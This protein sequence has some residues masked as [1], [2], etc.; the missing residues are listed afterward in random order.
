M[1]P[2]ACCRHPGVALL[3]ESPRALHHAARVCHNLHGTKRTCGLHA[4]DDHVSDR[5][6]V[7]VIAAL[8]LFRAHEE[9]TL[10]RADERIDKMISLGVIPTVGDQGALVRVRR[11]TQRLLVLPKPRHSLIQERSDL[12]AHIDIA[13]DKQ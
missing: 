8:Q 12:C 9:E 1:R 7:L 10:G 4:L 6:G 13:K 3:D 11:S 2:V 5:L